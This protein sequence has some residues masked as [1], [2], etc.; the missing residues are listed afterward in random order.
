MLGHNQLTEDEQL[1]NQQFYKLLTEYRGQ[2]SDRATADTNIKDIYKRASTF[3]IPN[4][5]FAFAE[6]LRNGDAA[7]II[8][9]LEMKLWVA[10]ATGHELGRQF[11]MFRGDRAPSDEI[12]YDKG[13]T[14]GA[15]R[16]SAKNP[17]DL[18][19][20]DGQAWQRG[21]NEGTAF[22]NKELANKMNE[23]EEQKEPEAPEEEA[24]KDPEA[25]DEET[26][27]DDTTSGEDDYQA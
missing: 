19:S 25:G 1:R 2:M 14:A 8:A 11:D 4:G 9:D 18:G 5:A 15:M 17:Y 12:A 7:E 24:G 21:F 6:R 16:S 26:S 10:R 3:Q 23:A 27:E 13:F 20:A 22:I